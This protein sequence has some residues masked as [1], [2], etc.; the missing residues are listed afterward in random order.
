MHRSLRAFT[1]LELMLAVGIMG[2]MLAVT[3]VSFRSKWHA[4][5]GRRG[6]Q[7]VAVAWLKA[8]SMA[9]REGRE[10]QVAWESGG[11]RLHAM[12]VARETTDVVASEDA[13]EDG[14]EDPRAFTVDLGKS[15]RLLSDDREGDPSTVH[16]LSNGRTREASVRVVDSQGTIWRVRTDWA[17]I[18]VME[19]VKTV[20]KKP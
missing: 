8:R 2:L 19:A 14:A 16:F 5:Q 4:E 3:T 6:A 13:L 11:S 10:W 9:W 20:E 17:G 7:R 12:P 18:P 1:L 15:I